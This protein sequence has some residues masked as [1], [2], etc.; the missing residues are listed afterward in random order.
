[1]ITFSS[2]H[3]MLQPT[4]RLR[5][6]CVSSSTSSPRRTAGCALRTSAFRTF[7]QR[8]RLAKATLSQRDLQQH[9]VNAKIR[10]GELQ[11][12]A[13]GIRAR[14]LLAGLPLSPARLAD[15]LH[16]SAWCGDRPEI[17][18]R[19]AWKTLVAL[20]SPNLPTDFRMAIEARIL[21]G[22]RISMTDVRR[23]I[24]SERLET[25]AE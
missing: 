4:P 16:V 2:S 1:M 13:P 18:R 9:V 10:L 6:A 24:E 12:A 25:C 17:C 11:R 14:N 20:A 8:R 5:L 21:Q 22:E 23:V 3:Q 19:V 15:L 7:E